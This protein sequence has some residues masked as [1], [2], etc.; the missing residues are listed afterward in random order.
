MAMIKGAETILVLSIALI[1]LAFALNLMKGVGLE[2][3]L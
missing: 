1:P 2:L 3:Y